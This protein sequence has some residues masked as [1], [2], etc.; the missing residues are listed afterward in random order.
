MVPIKFIY[1]G[2]TKRATSFYR[3]LHFHACIHSVFSE[4]W[5][6]ISTRIRL[7]LIQNTLNHLQQTTFVN[8]HLHLQ[9]VSLCFSP[10]A[11]LSF[12][13]V[14]LSNG[15]T[16]HQLYP[17]S[18]EFVIFQN[19]SRQ[20]DAL[21][22]DWAENTTS[23]RELVVGGSFWLISVCLF[24]SSFERREERAKFTIISHCMYYNAQQSQCPYW[25]FEGF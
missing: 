12:S 2:W 14:N 23:I 3:L 18:S 11:P 16:D 25:Q 5:L 22:C 15:R 20:L 13:R 10:F 6:S 19:S 4:I 7:Y 17:Q 24:V 1:S 8:L 9:H 21:S